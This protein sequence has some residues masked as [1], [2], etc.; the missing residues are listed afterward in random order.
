MKRFTRKLLDL[1]E[2]GA[3]VAVTI[4]GAITGFLAIAQLG[5]SIWETTFP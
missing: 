5:I 1:S 2:V 4:T 3:V